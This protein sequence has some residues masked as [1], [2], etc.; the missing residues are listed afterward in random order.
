MSHRI[1][2]KIKLN[3]V[4]WKMVLDA[5]FIARRAK[6]GQFV[7]V[8]IDEKGERIPLTINDS[9]AREGAIAIIFQEAGATTRHLG[10]LNKGDEVSD[11]LG[12]LGKET[13]FGN[14]GR[15]VIVAGGVG[16]T[17]IL[18]IAKY[19][20]TKS[21]YVLTIIGA[22]TKELLILEEELKTYSDKLIV[23]TDDGSYGIKGLVP[24]PLREAIAAETF[25]LCYCVGPD[26]MMKAVSET[27]RPCGLRTLVS[28]D[29]NMVDAT[30]MCGTC[31]VTV[32]GKTQ[33]VCVDGPEFDGHL[34]DWDGFLKRQK[35]FAEEERKAIEHF[36]SHH[37]NCMFQK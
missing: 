22:R 29:A 19:A 12:P 13:D 26:I 6:A 8:K 2:K 16:I 35:R 31:R 3:S 1:L 25:N 9:D 5:P 37:K 4:T 32:G 18:P 14:V 36:E 17:E 21:N 30:G 7:I 11:L 33:F 28:L 20:K 34:V 15:V 27:T 24:H 23:T 10:C